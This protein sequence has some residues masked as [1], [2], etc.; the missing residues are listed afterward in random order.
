MWEQG[1][2]DSRQMAGAFQLLRSNDLVWS[3]SVHQY[4][5]GERPAMTD[6]LAWNAD[7]TRMPFRMHSEYLREL[8]LD[9]D[10]PKDA[11]WRTEPPSR[12]P[13]FACPFATRRVHTPVALI[14][15]AEC[16]LR[17]SIQCPGIRS[18]TRHR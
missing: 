9:N 13:T 6:L 11:I 18:T 12:F 2:L 17:R 15:S 14:D 1:F 4:L 16:M 3:R 8:F 10:L 5:L 7:G